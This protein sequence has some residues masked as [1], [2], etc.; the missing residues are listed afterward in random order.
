MKLALILP[1]AFDNLDL[2]IDKINNIKPMEII[3]GSSHGFKLL[4]QARQ[5]FRLTIDFKEALGEK[6][7]SAYNAI[8]EADEILIFHNG[9][10]SIRTTRSSAALNRAM[11]T[12]KK[13]YVFSYSADAL[14]IS[15]SESG[16]VCINPQNKLL[17]DSGVN[18]VYL[19]RNE[20]SKLIDSLQKTLQKLENSEF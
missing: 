20:L 1:D 18:G 17:K 5:T 11:K 6:A 8:E 13:R 12:N 9:S 15:V 4:N 14:E 16:Y 2:M 7:D 19:K 10:G 3:S